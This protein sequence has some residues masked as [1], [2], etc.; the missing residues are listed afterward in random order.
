MALYNKTARK[1]L[2]KNVIRALSS[3]K[4]TDEFIQKLVQPNTHSYKYNS[5]RVR[6]TLKRGKV[7]HSEWYGLFNP[8]KLNISADTLSKLKRA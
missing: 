7:Y 1:V 4:D 8:A 5:D 3:A 6:N 2:G